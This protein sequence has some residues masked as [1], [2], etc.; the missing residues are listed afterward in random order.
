MLVQKYKHSRNLVLLALLLGRAFS[1]GKRWQNDNGMC[2]GYALGKMEID[3][4]LMFLFVGTRI[5]DPLELALV[6]YT[7]LQMA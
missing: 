7:G 1:S 6:N 2:T 3:T 4:F 5:F